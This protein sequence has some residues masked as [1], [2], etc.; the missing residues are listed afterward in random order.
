MIG[1][2]SFLKAIKKFKTHLSAGK[3]MA[4]VFWDSERVIHVGFLPHG[5]KINAQYYYN[6]LCN[7]VHQAIRKR[8]PGKLSKKITYCMT[9][10]VH[11]W[12]I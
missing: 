4:S 6:L 8:R 7:D 1:I 5:I 2:I 3:I 12:Q 10:L 9:T 11:I